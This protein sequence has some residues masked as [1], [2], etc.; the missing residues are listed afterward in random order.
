MRVLFASRSEKPED[1]LPRLREALPQDEFFV[2]GKDAHVALVANP[3]AGTLERLASAKLIQS[4]GADCL[5]DV[6]QIPCGNCQGFEIR[7]AYLVAR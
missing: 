4:L 2:E 1:W 5:N 3:P 7:R 6:S